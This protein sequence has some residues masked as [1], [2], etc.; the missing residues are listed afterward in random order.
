MARRT[1]TGP[2]AR[3]IAAFQ[4]RYGAIFEKRKLAALTLSNRKSQLARIAERLGDVVI[5]PRQEDAFII[6]EFS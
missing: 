4:E 2:V 5:G 1:T 6:N 3:T